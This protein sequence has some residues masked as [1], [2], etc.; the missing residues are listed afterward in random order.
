MD[1]QIFIERL[2]LDSKKSKDKDFLIDLC[3]KNPNYSSILLSNMGKINNENSNF[4]ARILEIT[5]KE[6]IE[7][8]IPYLAIFC[9]LLNKVSFNSTI[10]SCSKIY[11]LLM[12]EFFI[13]KNLKIIPSIQNKDLEKIVDKAVNA[14]KIR[15][16]K[17]L[18]AI[19]TNSKLKL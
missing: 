8:I 6:N 12:I 5:I 15:G 13:K 1:K 2:N 16:R 19:K 18:K 9:D 4:S 10:R 3:H 14:Y 17:V 7:V 11:E